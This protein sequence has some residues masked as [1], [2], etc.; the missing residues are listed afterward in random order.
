MA[1]ARMNGAALA[2]AIGLLL[3]QGSGPAS[4]PTPWCGGGADRD[5]GSG[6]R[7]TQYL[8]NGESDFALDHEVP[9]AAMTLHGARMTAPFR[10][11]FSQM[12]FETAGG[13]SPLTSPHVGFAG[14]EFRDSA[15]HR[16]GIGSLRLD[17]GSGVRLSADLS[18]EP[19]SDSVRAPLVFPVPFIGQDER[20]CIA[21]LE[22]GGR[23]RWTF[24]DRPDAVP[25]LAID[26]PLPLRRATTEARR[27][28]QNGLRE[29]KR[30][31]CRLKPPP[32]PPF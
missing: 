31:R 29:A 32:P 27:R 24:A 8:F 2:A 28:W 13:A 10:V 18:A 25:W 17:C 22:K 23:L 14:Y 20:G 6:F 19:P 11:T 12:R 4:P 9:A 1:E 26:A 15:G 30:G 3:A 7:L 16:K 21:A 5:I